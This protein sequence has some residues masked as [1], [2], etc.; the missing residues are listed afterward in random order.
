MISTHLGHGK[1]PLKRRLNVI[2]GLLLSKGLHHAGTWHSLAK[3]ELA[4]VHTAIMKIYRSLIGANRPGCEHLTDQQVLDKVDVI[5]PLTYVMILRISL[6]IKIVRTAAPPMLLVL[7]AAFNAKHSWLKTVLATLHKLAEKAE[8]LTELRDKPIMDWIQC[9][10]NQ[11]NLMQ[12]SCIKA[13]L[14]PELN[15]ADSWGYHQT[16]YLRSFPI[17]KHVIFVHTLVPL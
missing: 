17:P 15:K 2:K 1:Y 6:F 7:S 9:I 4:K 16:R 12:R 3:G 13:L 11:P 14:H 10:R 8:L 5:A